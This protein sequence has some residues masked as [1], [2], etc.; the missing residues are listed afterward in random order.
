MKKIICTLTGLWLWPFACL[1]IEH[2]PPPSQ[3]LND[4]DAFSVARAFKLGR[5]A[6]IAANT[7]K[8]NEASA[9]AQKEKYD[10][11][12]DK[13]CSSSQKCSNNKCLDACIVS[14]CAAGKKCIAAAH[15][16]SCVDCTADTH[17]TAGNKCSG[18]DCIPCRDGETCRC[19]TGQ[20]ANGSGACHAEDKCKNITCEAGKKCDGTTGSCKTCS[21]GDKCGCSGSQVANGIGGCYTPDPCENI[22]CE[23]GKRCSGGTCQAIAGWCSDDSGCSEGYTCVNNSCSAISGYCAGDS[24]CASNEECISNSC[25][26]VTCSSVCEEAK[27][28]QCVAKSGCCTS[29]SDCGSGKECKNNSCSSISGYCSSNSDCGASEKCSGNSCV[30][31]SCGT[32]EEVSNHACVKKSGCC[33]SNSDCGSSEKC[34]GNKCVDLCSGVTCSGGKTCKQ[35]TCSCPADKP[36]WNGSACYKDMCGNCKSYEYCSGNKCV[37]QAGKCYTDNDCDGSDK[38]QSN[39]CVSACIS[40]PCS[41]KTPQ[42]LGVSHKPVCTCTSTSCGA[43]YTCNTTVCKSTG[44]CSSDNDC[45]KAMACV[46]GQ[47]KN[48]CAPNPCSGKTPQCLGVSHK[49]VCACTSTS[50]GTGYTCDVTACKVATTEKCSSD[51]D[52]SS[53][54]QCISGYCVFKN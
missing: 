41:G 26:A 47:C 23:A 12:R 49:A 38:C 31:L 33:M 3:P 16:R 9:A 24:A 34:S 14:P 52:C 37:L 43:G 22:T 35:G 4:S 29:D 27:N 2:L 54:K 21:S 18:N 11:T 25:V 36:D 51:K 6:D 44:S 42:C 53:E 30:A 46:S 20:V 28:H 50:C 45:D 40:N 10:C 17:C 13:D 15:T 48:V 5:Q 39:S 19:A 7:P 1:A 8:K 32:C